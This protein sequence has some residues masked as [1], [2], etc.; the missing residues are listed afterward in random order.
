MFA[1]SKASLASAIQRGDCWTYFPTLT[2]S[3]LAGDSMLAGLLIKLKSWSPRHWSAEWFRRTN[4]KCSER[5]A[6]LTVWE[7]KKGLARLGSNSMKREWEE[8]G[9]TVCHFGKFAF[10]N[11]TSR[12]NADAQ[13]TWLGGKQ[14]KRVKTIHI[15]IFLKLLHKWR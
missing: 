13:G 5:S 2:V 15:L 6:W 14:K 10:L 11:H 4:R 8:K 3:E 1:M 7:E 9:K 12:D